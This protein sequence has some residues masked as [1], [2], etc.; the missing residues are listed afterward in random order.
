M[1]WSPDHKARTRERIVRAAS[2][3]FR[4]RGYEQSGVDEVMAAADLTRGGFYAHFEGKSDLFAEALERAFD[5]SEHNLFEGRL[6]GLEG[7]AWHA[8]AAARYLATKHRDQPEAGCPIPALG[9]EVTRGPRA[10]RGRFGARVARVVDRIAERLGGGPGARRRAIVLLSTWAGAVLLA[11]AVG[12]RA[13][14][15]EILD[16]ARA[17][18]APP[19]RRAR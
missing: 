19:R 5:E 16:A 18:D 17:A 4:R 11:R 3:L 13:L 15:D 2:K 12:D 8:A 9:A 1:P 14:A 10:L 6:A 7:D